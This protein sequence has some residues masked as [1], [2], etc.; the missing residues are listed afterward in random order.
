[1]TREQFEHT[2]T[3]HYQAM[4]KFAGYLG[5]SGDQVHDT[6]ERLCV[7]GAYAKYDFE[8]DAPRIPAWLR[9]AIEFT[10]KAERE[11]LRRRQHL[12]AVDL[13]ERA[14]IGEAIVTGDGETAEIAIPEVAGA[15]LLILRE[16]KAYQEALAVALA[17]ELA[18]DSVAPDVSTGLRL[19]F[20]HDQTW[21]DAGRATG[22][23]PEALRKRVTRARP[24]IRARV[25]AA[26]S[27]SEISRTL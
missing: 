20:A 3:R 11:K 21:Q 7:T 1:M 17:A 14:H 18:G 24:G 26:M 27:G 23:P 15:D 12:L 19:V 9:R 5:A 2:V 6:V 10:V 4:M 16:E 25:L 13:E 8:P 22:V